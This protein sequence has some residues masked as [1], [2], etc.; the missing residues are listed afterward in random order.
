[1]TSHTFR[2]TLG[3]ERPVVEVP[4]D[5]PTVFGKKRVPVKGTVNGTPFRTT[6]AVYGDR[7]YIGF[8]KAL[9]DTAGISLGEEVEV[10]LERDDEPREIE[11]PADLGAALR[12]SLDAKGAFEQLSYTHRREYVEWITEAKKRETRD[13]RVAK[14]IEMLSAGVKHP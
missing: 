5:V 13:R 8:N 12:S 11:V 10:E 2:A 1:M 9:R 3:D 6:I 7:Y 14:A 4:V